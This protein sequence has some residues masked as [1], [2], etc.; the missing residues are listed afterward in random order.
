MLAGEK[1]CRPSTRSGREVAAAMRVRVE[2]AGVGRE[3]RI[4]P[5]D[6]V[7]SPEQLGLDV[8]IV[9]HRLDHEIG[10]RRASSLSP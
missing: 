6:G 3:H 10:M 4:R 2:I 5:H 1:K 7:E 9:E 8:E